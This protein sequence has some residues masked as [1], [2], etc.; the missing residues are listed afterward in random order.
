MSRKQC[1][2]VA[3]L[4]KC[5]PFVRVKLSPKLHV[6]YNSCL[7][8]IIDTISDPRMSLYKK[9]EQYGGTERSFW[10]KMVS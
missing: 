7:L 9:K 10:L 4:Q 1:C 5:V 8:Q 6:H 2:T 3:A